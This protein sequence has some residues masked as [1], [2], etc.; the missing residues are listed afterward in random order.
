MG[1]LQQAR[2]DYNKVFEILPQVMSIPMV[3]RKTKWF[4]S[5]HIDGSYSQRWDKLVCRLVDDGIQVLE[6]GGEAISLFA[7]MMKYGGCPSPEQAKMRLIALGS[8]VID[9]PEHFEKKKPAKFVPRGFMERSYEFRLKNRDNFSNFMAATF[10]VSRAEFY[11]RKYFVGSATYP[12]KQPDGS[13]KTECLTQFW[14]IN[15]SGSVCHDKLML[16]K[17]DGH[18]DHDYGGGRR[19]RV[20]SGFS[21][22]CLFGE[23]LLK[24][25]TEGEKVYVVESEK[26]ALIAAAYFGKGIWLATGGLKNTKGLD[27]KPDYTILPDI[28]GYEEWNEKYPG[29]CSRWWEAYM[30]YEPG[31]KDDVGDLVLNY[32]MKK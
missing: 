13:S 23:H 32:L 2:I 5:R 3:R 25:R 29:Q 8:A 20:G 4:A 27:I 1:I 10:G 26:T 31:P 15:E 18:R 17:T 19:F 30:G 7:W 28:D 22:R 16:Y 11:L 14:F 24:D 9:V 12:V 6:Q 21:N